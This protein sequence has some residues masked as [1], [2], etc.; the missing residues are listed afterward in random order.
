MKTKPYHVIVVGGGPAGTSA[1]Y[2]LAKEGLHVALLEKEDIPRYKPCGGVIAPH[3]ERLLNFSIEPVIERKITYVRVTVD[4]QD[5]FLTNS[6][7]PFAY[8]AMRDT[9]DAFLVDK[10]LEA[11]AELY[12]SHPVE[13]ISKSNDEY[14]VASP[15]AKFKARY[16]VAADGANS[17]VRKLLNM[18]R[19]QRLSIAVEREIRGSV[20]A[21]NTWEE[22]IALD[23]GHLSSGYAWVFPK[24]NNFSI[25]A[26]GPISV[27][28][29]LKPYC[30]QVTNYYRDEIG[31][32]SP[33]IE[34]GHHLPIRTRG[35]QIIK[36]K[37]VFIGDAAGLI[38]P[39]AGEGIYYAIRS[40]QIAAETIIG[41]LN[42]GEER[43]YE[44]EERINAEIQAEIQVAKSL[45]FLLDLAPAYWVP[46]VM[47]PDNVF[48]EFYYRIFT[49]D[50]EYQDIRN[51]LGWF[52]KTA[53]ALLEKCLGN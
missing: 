21:L 4:L 50:K 31:N 33:F 43:I 47:Q 3:V 12:A 52:S 9:F 42:G 49:G 39:M 44:Y 41:C 24:A 51:K 7:V 5:P 25:G 53:F 36:G 22:T 40:G 14:I 30:D 17:T 13:H 23:F 16:I 29:E 20:E 46:R 34:R 37:T 38:D 6:S 19:F 26:G 28:E 32:P 18:P 11:G 1:A 35:E 48:W 10:A 8:L 27:A 45:L 2:Q 15:E